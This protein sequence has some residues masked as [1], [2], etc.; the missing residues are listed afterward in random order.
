MLRVIVASH[1]VNWPAVEDAAAAGLHDAAAADDVRKL[2]LR[3]PHYLSDYSL[4]SVGRQAVAGTL[5]EIFCSFPLFHFFAHGSD[6][7]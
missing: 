6:P 1:V 5:C 7:H 4:C 2:C 3:S